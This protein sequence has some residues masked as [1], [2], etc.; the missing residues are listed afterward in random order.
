[1]GSVKNK[2]ISLLLFLCSFASLAL[3]SCVRTSSTSTNASSLPVASK[4]DSE[5]EADASLG[6]LRQKGRSEAAKMADEL[7]SEDEAAKA[8]RKLS[9]EE[10]QRNLQQI[11]RSIIEF[12]K[13]EQQLRPSDQ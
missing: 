9:E 13:T 3:V 1:M 5:A 4:G 8:Q 7:E 12:D 11:H 2:S 10:A 6:T